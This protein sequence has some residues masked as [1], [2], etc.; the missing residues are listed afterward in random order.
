MRPDHRMTVLDTSTVIIGGVPLR[1]LTVQW[2]TWD[3]MPPDTLR[4]RIGFSMNYLNGSWWFL[5]DLPWVGL[6]CYRDSELSFYASGETDCGFTLS[7]NNARKG[8]SAGVFP[9]PGTD[10]FTLNDLVPS[11]TFRIYDTTG[12]CIFT[13]RTTSERMEV[14]ARDFAPGV[15]HI[16]LEDGKQGLSSIKE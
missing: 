7:I 8:V 4:E 11:T 9:N 12:R 3:W 6:R 5:T 15:Y 2:G 1:E 14:D 16:R 10:H 13:G